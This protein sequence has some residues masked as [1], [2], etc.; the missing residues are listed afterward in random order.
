[1]IDPG[2]MKSFQ[3]TTPALRLFGGAG[4]LAFLGRELDRLSC[5]RA[6]IFCGRTLSQDEKLVGMLQSAMGERCVGMFAGV[7]AHSPIPSVEAG[8]AELRRLNADA[9]IAVGG[10]S[11]VVSAR[12]ASI[13]LAEGRHPSQLCTSTNDKGEQISPKL[14]APKLPQFVVPTT[15]NTAT[16]KAGSAVFDPVRAKRMA[17]FDPKTR[18]QAV[19]IEPEFLASAP[20]ELLISASLD[21]FALAAEAL[22]SP[23]GDR[24]SDALLMHALRLASR[25]LSHPNLL[26]DP[27]VRGDLMMAAV[28]CGQGTDYTGAGAGN[29]IGHAIG[30]RHNVENG[31]I[32]AIVL[33][34]V[35]RFNAKVVQTGLRKMAIS[36]DA[37]TDDDGLLLR[38]VTDGLARLYGALGLPKLLRDVGV[39]KEALPEIAGIAAQDWFLRFS[40]RKINGAEDIQR[41]LEACW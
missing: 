22:I 20:R 27:V 37:V 13:L 30:A 4:S 6:A 31:V 14:L 1:M 38:A 12:A 11:A 29:V 26:D 10:G 18:A 25:H 34:E 40:P 33:P 35:L 32:K 3:H 36:L 39:P 17:M 28:L 21:S 8:S 23:S 41:L 2:S 5:R 24:I 7:K 19:F 9:V 15:P 16:V